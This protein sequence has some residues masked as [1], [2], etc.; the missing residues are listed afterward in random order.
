MSVGFLGRP[1]DE[2]V[3]TL[4][5]V[6]QLVRPLHVATCPGISWKMLP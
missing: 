5:N 3:Q 2:L 6:E 4:R 1:A